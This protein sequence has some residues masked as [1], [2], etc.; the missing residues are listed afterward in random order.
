MISMIVFALIVS[1]LLALIKYNEKSHIA[2][3]TLKLFIFMTCGTIIFAW[4]MKIL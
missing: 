2:K 1:F 3:Y 4:I